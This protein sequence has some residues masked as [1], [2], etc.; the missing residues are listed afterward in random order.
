MNAPTI[1]QIPGAHDAMAGLVA[2]KAGFSA[3]YLS[4]A[5]FTASLGLP[6]LGI[7]T[8]AEVAQ[9]AKK[10]FDQPIYRY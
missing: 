3:L 10:S 2:K 8:S 1:L 9:R 5:A 4:G 7:I 6:D